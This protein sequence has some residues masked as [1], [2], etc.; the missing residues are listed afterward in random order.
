MHYR[1]TQTSTIGAQVCGDETLMNG[2][3]FL[4][5]FIRDLIA[6][7]NCQ[8]IKAFDQVDACRTNLSRF[9]RTPGFDALRLSGRACAVIMPSVALKHARGLSVVSDVRITAA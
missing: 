6:D 8:V 5:T 1:R 2:V 4:H 9:W 3:G 7:C